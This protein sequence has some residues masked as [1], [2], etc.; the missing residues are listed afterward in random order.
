MTKSTM[1]AYFHITATFL[2][3]IWCQSNEL[4]ESY[5]NYFTP[6]PQLKIQKIQCNIRGS[7]E[8]NWLLHLAAIREMISWCFAHDKVNYA[9]YL[10]YYYASMS[11]LPTEHPDVHAHFMEG[12]F[13]VQICSQNPFGRIPVDQTIEETVNKDTK[14]SVPQAGGTKGFSLK[15]GAVASASA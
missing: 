2:C 12:G 11:Q 3:H 8:G 7:R 6:T 5:I 9:S 15:S 14:T 1:Q 13:S 4:L 10:T